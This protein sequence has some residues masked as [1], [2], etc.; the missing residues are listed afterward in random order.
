MN[1]STHFLYF[2]AHTNTAGASIVTARRTNRTR[3]AIV[4]ESGIAKRKEDIDRI[5]VR[6][7]C[8]ACVD[9]FLSLKA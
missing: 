8:I 6:R 2:C 9:G 3:K 5:N 1:V 7:V 4:L